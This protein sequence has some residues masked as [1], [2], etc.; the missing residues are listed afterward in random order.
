MTNTKKQSTVSIS[1]TFSMLNRF[2]L[3]YA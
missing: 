2:L 1:L 3:L